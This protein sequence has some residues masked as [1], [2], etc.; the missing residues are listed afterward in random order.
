MRLSIER[1]P[2]ALRPVVTGAALAVCQDAG[3]RFA[4]Q[5]LSCC[6]EVK[7]TPVASGAPQSRETAG[8]V[9]AR[10]PSCDRLPV[11]R[12]PGVGMKPLL[13]LFSDMRRYSQ[14]SEE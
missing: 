11:L 10:R 2:W 6:E 4:C 9:H 12:C 3:G 1:A 14:I 5:I 8:V 7:D 13:L